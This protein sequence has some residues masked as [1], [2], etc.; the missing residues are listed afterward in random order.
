MRDARDRRSYK[1][2]EIGAQTWMAE[3]LNY[4]TRNS[5]CY[6]NKEENC[7]KY[8]R[9]YT[10]NAAIDACPTGWHLPTKGVILPIF[11]IT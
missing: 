3:K 6:A 9:L 8:G 2:I 1:T 7:H 4:K 10:W 5:W 11:G